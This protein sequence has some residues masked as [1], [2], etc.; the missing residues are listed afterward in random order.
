M[1]NE[2]RGKKRD[3][4]QAAS[5]HGCISCSKG[6]R[7]VHPERALLQK[8]GQTWQINFVFISPSNHSRA[9]RENQ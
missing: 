7:F 8:W 5:S 2:L 4:M 1:A 6:G 3:G 9:R